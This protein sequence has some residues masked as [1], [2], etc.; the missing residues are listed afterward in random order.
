MKEF[1]E[2]LDFRGEG[3]SRHD[4]RDVQAHV[5]TKCRYHRGYRGPRLLE[6]QTPSLQIHQQA[7]R[8]WS[9]HSGVLEGSDVGLGVQANGGGA[10]LEGIHSKMND[11]LDI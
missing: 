5:L 10:R 8:A 11:C 1:Q 7:C 2:T 3:L 9:R 6:A 4:R